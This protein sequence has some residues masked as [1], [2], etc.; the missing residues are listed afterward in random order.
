[1]KHLRYIV[2]HPSKIALFYKDSALKVFL[3]FALFASM[4][5]GVLAAQTFTARYFDN[6]DIDYIISL[7]DKQ[8]EEIN[9]EYS[10][11]KITGDPVAIKD[12]NF[13]CYIMTGDETR[14]DKSCL[15]MFLKEDN[16]NIYYGYRLIGKIEYKNIGYDYHFNVSNVRNGINIDKYNFRCFFYD[17][18]MVGNT[19]YAFTVFLSNILGA[20]QYYLI[21]ALVIMF[22]Y[23]YFINPSIS[24]GVRLKLIVYDSLVYFVVMFFTFAFQ[25]SF[26]QYVALFIP[27]I[28]CNVTFSHIIRVRR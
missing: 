27:L 19:G 1:M 23:S 2:C 20:F 28:Y 4:L 24:A 17:L 25:I 14:L 8:K 13:E 6:D 18:L 3:F 9:I 16:V 7:F 10:N 22:I 21:F 15:I 11:Y 26:L 12:T 5:I